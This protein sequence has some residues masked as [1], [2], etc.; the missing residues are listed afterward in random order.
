[1]EGR[2]QEGAARLCAAIT[3][4]LALDPLDGYLARGLLHNSGWTAAL[5]AIDGLQDIT[6]S[7]TDLAQADVVPQLFRRHDT[8]F[9]ALVEPWKL[10]PALDLLA[11]GGRQPWHRRRAVTAWRRFARR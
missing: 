4:Q 8:L 9:G 5:R 10:S 2:R 7:A 11:A 6:A 1:M 3:S